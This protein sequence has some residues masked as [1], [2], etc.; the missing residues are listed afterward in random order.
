MSDVHFRRL[1]GSLIATAAALALLLGWVGVQSFPST[2]AV[3]LRN[4]LLMDAPKLGV[5]QW[6]PNSP[7]PGFLSEELAVPDSVAQAAREAVT[8]TGPDEF[9]RSRALVAHLL[10]KVQDSGGIHAVG[11]EATYRAIVDEGRGY[12]SDYITA[13][14]AMAHALGIPV[15]TWA[16]SFDGFGGYGHIV[17]EIYDRARGQW[18]MLDVFNNVHPVSRISGRPLSALEFR[19][20]FSADPDVVEFVQIGPGRLA[21]SDDDKLREYYLHG[22]D[23]WYLWNG[24]NVVTR[25]EAA[26]Y[27]MLKAVPGAAQLLAIGLG[28][29]PHIVPV[30]TTTNAPDIE[31]MRALGQQLQIVLSLVFVLA[32][33]LLVQVLLFLRAVRRTRRAEAGPP[34]H[35]VAPF[36]TEEDRHA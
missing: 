33:A 25:G 2:E 1:R 3:R 21:Y 28:D 11:L 35:E 14:V 36:R 7:P 32:L 6:Q 4:A 34:G 8:G 9:S 29:Y 24:N 27:R 31:R 17:A 23:Q 13:F 12:C 22:L 19:N 10:H 16:F 20:R 15:R 5:G 30:A 26:P 18:V